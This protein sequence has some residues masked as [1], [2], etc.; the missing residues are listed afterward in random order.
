MARRDPMSEAGPSSSFLVGR[1]AEL[2]QIE[3]VVADVAHG[4][5]T[6]RIAGDPGVGKSALLRAGTELAIAQGYTTLSVRATEGEAHLAF[7]ALYQLLRPILGRVD[8]LPDGHRAA[9]MSAFGLAE[10]GDAPPNR[11]FI[12]LAA[13]ELLA[14]AAAGTPVLVGVDDMSWLDEAS[15]E[16]IEFISR[17][18]TD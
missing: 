2:A 12:A 14:D 16:A 6:M 4:G 8:E 18:I 3:S 5:G 13:L 10:P 1:D 9:L 15:R 7:A 11:F 17:R